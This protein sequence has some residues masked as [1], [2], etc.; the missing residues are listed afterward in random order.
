MDKEALLARRLSGASFSQIGAEFGVS[1]QRVSQILS[2]PAPIRRQ[3]VERAGGKCEDCGIAV[4]RSGHVH[5]GLPEA[6][7]GDWYNAP[8][9]LQLLCPSCHRAKHPI[10]GDVTTLAP[11][12]V[13]EGHSPR[14]IARILKSKPIRVEVRPGAVLVRT[15]N[16]SQMADMIIVQ[17]EKAGF[18]VDPKDRVRA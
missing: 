9:R 5:H 17:A 18:P 6:L 2:P 13:A 4:G 8:E 7:D 3:V 10:P 11:T 16:P 15:D 1:R 14:A 12:L